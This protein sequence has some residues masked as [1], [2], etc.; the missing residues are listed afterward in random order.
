VGKFKSKEFCLVSLANPGRPKNIYFTSI[1]FYEPL[2]LDARISDSESPSFPQALPRFVHPFKQ[3]FPQKHLYYFPRVLVLQTSKPF[4]W[5]ATKLLSVLF[6][7]LY[8]PYLRG[9]PPFKLTPKVLSVIQPRP[10]F[11]TIKVKEF[12]LSFLFSFRLPKQPRVDLSF[13][14]Q[15]FQ[16]LLPLF[17]EPGLTITEDTNL[18]LNDFCFPPSRL[19]TFLQLFYCLILERQTV[20]VHPKP[21]HLFG[22]LSSFLFP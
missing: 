16:S 3:A 21:G 17:H 9:S 1:Y 22:L 2:L 10:T 20:V 7:L 11:S 15:T 5:L 6:R 13:E 8:Q 18:L 4:F 14:L 19:H 12:F